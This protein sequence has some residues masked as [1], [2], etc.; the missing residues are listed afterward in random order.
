[1]LMLILV[2][3][4]C[5]V[6]PAMADGDVRAT[7]S[8]SGNLKIIG[9]N[10]GNQIMVTHNGSGK[11]RVEGMPGTTVNDGVEGWD[12]PDTYSETISGK[13]DIILKGGDNYVEIKDIAVTGSLQLKFGHGDNTIGIFNTT[14]L[15]DALLRMGHGDNFIAIAGDTWIDD[16]LTIN[17][18]KGNDGIEI[19]ECV[20][21]YG[22][23]MIKTHSGHDVINLRGDYFGPLTLD[24]GSDNDELY[25]S[26]YTNGNR[27]KIFLGNDD[28]MILFASTASL[29]G[30]V[31]IN[32]G[33]GDDTIIYDDLAIV[34]L[35]TKASKFIENSTVQPDADDE[36]VTITEQ[37]VQDY[38]VRGGDPADISCPE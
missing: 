33:K 1:M 23:T 36:P 9:D 28:D 17:T 7:M 38:T 5:H 3:I 2:F 21:I 12:F 22:K 13:L 20:Y 10:R 8:S 11:I 26:Q 19:A 37:M 32:G 6:L 4:L 25:I 31:T 29:T 30:R 27:V 35:P 14:V 16:K 15:D 24:A 34:F 18:S